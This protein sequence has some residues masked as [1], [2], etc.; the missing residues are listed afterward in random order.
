MRDQASR[1]VRGAVLAIWAMAGLAAFVT[2]TAAQLAADHFKGKS[3]D[4]Y[5][6][7][8]TGGGYDVYARALARHFGRH[9]PGGPNVIVR[10]MPGAQTRVAANHLYSV[11]PKDGTAIGAVARG[12]PTDELLG[13]PGV[14]FESRKFAWLGSMNNEVSVGVAWEGSPVKTIAEARQKEMIV[15]GIA[16]SV[17]FA[18]VM[19]QVLGTKF[20][21]ITGYKS[22]TDVSLALERGEVYGRMG[23]S[24]SS[25][26]TGQMDL[27][28]SKKITL[29]VQFSTSKHADLPTVPLITDLAENP[30]DKKILELVFSR[31][32]I[33]RP[34]LAPPGLAPDVKAALLKAFDETMK[35]K[36]FVDDMNKQKLELNPVSGAEVEKLIADLFNTTPAVLARAKEIIKTG[37]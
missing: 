22:G 28:R 33:G 35:D 29:M 17:V 6:G 3:I 34:F 36:A 25:I 32:V 19:N 7:Y 26:A 30:D 13:A 14:R 10:N 12:L 23:W 4:L 15:G 2:P 16:D 27:V 1:A 8:E 11:A 20:K 24:W 9:L 21:I 5:V 31:Q 37:N 18:E